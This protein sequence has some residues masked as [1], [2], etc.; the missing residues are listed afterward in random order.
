MSIELQI[1]RR[2]LNKPEDSDEF[3]P[4]IR[5]TVTGRVYELVFDQG[6]LKQIRLNGETYGVCAMRLNENG[7]SRKLDI[8]YGGM[9]TILE[10]NMNNITDL[11]T[12]NTY[13]FCILFTNPVYIHNVA[14]T[15]SLEIDTLH[16]PI[17]T[18]TSQM[19]Q[20]ARC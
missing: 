6:R 5:Y 20:R 13:T 10:N 2:S 4:V 9:Q 15:T 12:A 17:L 19:L 1:A 3:V 8:L 11:Y 16:E 18:R 7:F 14:T